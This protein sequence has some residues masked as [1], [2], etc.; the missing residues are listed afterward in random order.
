MNLERL[1]EQWA[2]REAELGAGAGLNRRLLKAATLGRARSSLQRLS[3]ALA[4]ELALSAL[5]AVALGAFVHAR[6][7]QAR[8]AL[9]GALLELGAIA[10]TIAVAEHLAAARRVDPGGPIVATQRR[11]EALRARRIR[12]TLRVLL[13]SPLIWPLLV[14]VGLEGFFGLDAYEVLGAGWLAANA[15]FGAALVA[16]ALWLSRRF[17][18][19]AGGHPIVRRLARDLAGHNANAAAAFLTTLAEFEGEDR[20]RG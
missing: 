17:G 2:E 10:L 13:A 3:A 14:V 1:R 5:S 19:R 15:V 7:E 6:R 16:L 18:A 8:F 20:A 4:C 9:P 12:H 11:L